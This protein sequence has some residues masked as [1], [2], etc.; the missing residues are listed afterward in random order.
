MEKEPKRKHSFEKGMQK[1]SFNSVND[2]RSER[3]E[4][5]RVFLTS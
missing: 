2:I 4:F 3:V 1:I 5:F